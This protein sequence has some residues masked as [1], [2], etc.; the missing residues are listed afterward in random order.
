M[1]ALV[2]YA[3]RKFRKGFFARFSFGHTISVVLL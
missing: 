3:H 1:V 2:T